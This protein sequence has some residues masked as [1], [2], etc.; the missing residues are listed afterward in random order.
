MPLDDKTISERE[1]ELTEWRREVFA[2]WVS[3][4]RSG[5]YVQGRS[6]LKREDEDG[7]ISYCCLGVLLNRLD[8]NG[9][10]RA[11]DEPYETEDEH[12]GR[13]MVKH[14]WLGKHGQSTVKHG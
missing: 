6:C 1:A 13:R 9:Y 3:D 4:L 10:V 8:P 11:E 5:E 2:G 12:T 14:G 7:S